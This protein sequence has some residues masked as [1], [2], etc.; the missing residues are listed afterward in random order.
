ME[1]FREW[2]GLPGVVG[3]IDGTYFDIRKP[4]HSPK[5]YFNFKSGGYSMQC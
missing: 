4:H 2:C 1:D 5:D 3:A